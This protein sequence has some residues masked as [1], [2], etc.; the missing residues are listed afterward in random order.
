MPV[1]RE[2]R[3]AQAIEPGFRLYGRNDRLCANFDLRNMKLPQRIITIILTGTLIAPLIVSA[4]TTK[5]NYTAW[6]PYW[7]KTDGVAEAIEHLSAFKEISPFYYAV[8]SDG[9]LSDQMKIGDDPWP[10]LLAAATSTKVRVIPSI[11]W[12]DGDLIHKVL[13]D[14]KLRTAHI[15]AIADL[16]KAQN[17]DGID[18]D[19]EGKK[20]E[21]KNYF[22]AF[23]KELAAQPIFKKKFLVCT[24]E[25][26]TPADSRFVKVPKTLE[27]ANDYVAI[28]KYCDQVR[29]MAYDQ[30]RIDLK[31]NRAK[32]GDALYAPVADSV[33]VD[34]VIKEATRSIKAS[35]IYLGVPTYGY[36]YE[37]T[38]ANDAWQYDR[39]RSLGYKDALAL[40]TGL[41]TSPIRNSAGELSFT[42]TNGTSTRLVWFSDGQ[43]IQDKIAV[44]KKYRLGGLTI[45]KLDGTADPQLW[46]VINE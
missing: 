8:K 26:R 45:F 20:A 19:Y 1:V 35:K 14:K 27:F 34:K 46:N 31:L 36:E 37:I 24:I 2:S 16:V 7:K 10:K 5:L 11:L 6:I 9:S 18:I 38:R 44:A 4:A 22:S 32:G 39:L 42:Y 3:L 12:G 23:L 29:I 25:A 13:S 33:W 41:G 21:T 17:Y 40:A 30:I 43:A 15:Q 28:N